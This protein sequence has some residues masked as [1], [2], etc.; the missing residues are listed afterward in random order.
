MR[1]ELV[2]LPSADVERSKAF[3][4][5]RVGFT[6]DHD[7]E[8]GNGMRVVQLTPPGSGCSIVIGVG[9]SAPDAAPVQNLHL[10]VDD[11]EAVRATL[12]GNGVEVSAVSDL[13]GGI[14]HAYFSDPDGNSW[15]LQQISRPDAP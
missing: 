2:P 10:V 11:L 3:Y 6:L 7:V 12:L 14:R 8:P 4:A 9:I 1:L 13:G 5:D 15:V